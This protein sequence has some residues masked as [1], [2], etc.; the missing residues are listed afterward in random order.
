MVD[1]EVQIL[2][3]LICLVV[4]AE[5]LM[6]VVEGILAVEMVEMEQQLKFQ[7]VQQLM[8]VVEAEVFMDQSV[9]EL[10][11][12]QGPVVEGLVD[13]PL[14]EVV[15]LQEDLMVQLAQLIQVVAVAVELE[16]MHQVVVEVHLVE[17]VVAEW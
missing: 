15:Q 7:Q 13:N 11:V 16:L 9:Q 4:E 14:L 12:K 1:Q 6:L 17:T 3:T 2:E 8:Q 5:R 10:Q